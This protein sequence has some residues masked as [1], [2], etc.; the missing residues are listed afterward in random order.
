MI[1]IER[2]LNG[3]FF[4]NPSLFSNQEYAP[5]VEG[6]KKQTPAEWLRPSQKGWNHVRNEDII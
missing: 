4:P 1:F 2:F 3:V 6:A 5:Q